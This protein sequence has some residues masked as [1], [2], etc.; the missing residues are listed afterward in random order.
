[1]LRQG[2]AVVKTGVSRRY[3]KSIS[4]RQIEGNGHHQY[5][6]MSYAIVRYLPLTSGEA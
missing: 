1:M 6:S 2:I 4:L 5:S 3:R